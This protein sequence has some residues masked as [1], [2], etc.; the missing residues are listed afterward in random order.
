VEDPSNLETRFA[1]SRLRT[2]LWPALKAAFPD[3]EAALALSA[4]HAQSAVALAREVALDDLPKVSDVLGLDRQGWA[5]LRPA[6]QRNALRWWLQGSLGQFPPYTL[7]D[8]LMSELP[9]ARSGRWP[10]P[11][12]ELRLHRGH[13]VYA[14]SLTADVLEQ[15][16][17]EQVLDLSQP[18]RVSLAGWGGALVVSRCRSGGV[19]PGL[20]SRAK[21]HARQGGEQ[22]LLAPRATARSLKKQYQSLDIPAWARG[23]PLVSSQGGQLL[24]VPGLGM[25]AR[26]WAASGE[27]QLQLTWQPND[28]A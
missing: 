13:L 17:P 16:G 10:V 25:D 5:A 27:P 2:V 18:G 21:V 20:L 28:P 7:V 9:G 3:A 8:R 12:G 11:G 19:Q 4:R 14:P 1:R 26:A 15:G 24:F 6:R 22:F 23:G